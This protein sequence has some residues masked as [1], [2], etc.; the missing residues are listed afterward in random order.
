[1]GRPPAE[2][3]HRRAEFPQGAGEGEE[4]PAAQS[5]PGQRKRYLP[6]D[7]PAAGALQPGAFFQLARDGGESRLGRQIK[8]RQRHDRRR[9]RGPFEA[10]DDGVSELLIQPMAD[11]PARPQPENDQ[12][13]HHRRGKHHRHDHRALDQAFAG[14]SSSRHHPGDRDR[15]KTRN[16]RGDGGNAQREPE[17][18]P[19]LA[20][21]LA[22]AG[23]V[24]GGSAGTNPWAIS[25]VWPAGPSR[26]SRNLSAA[27]FSLLFTI[28]A[29]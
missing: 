1:M 5:P 14:K 13:S 17:W 23:L 9:Q 11:Q 20:H 19:Q 22:F 6:E 28:G 26:Y 3:H 18:S 21:G 25:A 16:H 10:E 2:D 29:A 4:Q 7:L 24:A 27:A 12:I 8:H 15:R